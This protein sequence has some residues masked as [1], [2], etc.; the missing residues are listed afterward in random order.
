MLSEAESFTATAVRTV[1]AHRRLVLPFFAQL[2]SSKCD[3]F[4][5]WRAGRRLLVAG[6]SVSIRGLFRRR[7]IAS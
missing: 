5:K 6:W 2:N 1:I 7:M 4:S 3:G